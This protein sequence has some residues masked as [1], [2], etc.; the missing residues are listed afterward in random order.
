MIGQRG[1]VLLRFG[2]MERALK[3]SRLG[4]LPTQPIEKLAGA[5][6]VL[7]ADKVRFRPL[8]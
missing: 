1:V 7:E 3:P 4:W 6:V 2:V 8:Q 5:F